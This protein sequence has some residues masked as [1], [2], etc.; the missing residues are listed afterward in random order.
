MARYIGPVCK[1]CRR[2]KTKLFLKGAKC[3]TIR[4]PMERRP[5]APGLHGRERSRQGSEY[6]VQLRE[7]QKARRIYG[8]LESQFKTYYEEATR[9]SGITGEIIV[10]LLERRL[11]NVVFR[12]GWAA[13]RSQA[14][15]MVRHGHILINNKKV[16]IPSYLVKIN[17][18]ISL[19]ESAK[20]MI[21]VRHNLDT[22]SR[23]VP[24]WLEPSADRSQIAVRN[25][26]TRDEADIPVKEQLIVELY[27]K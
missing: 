23:N 9:K 4:C 19:S 10:S 25:L 13:S 18:E 2:E 11:D 17:E 12:A 24:L 5:Y 6:L 27:S 22:I 15:Q 1:M 20:S 7:K 21:V 16:T 14:R 3:E 26:P 8:V